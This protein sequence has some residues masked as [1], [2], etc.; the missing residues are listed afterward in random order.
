VRG[1][2]ARPG[3]TLPRATEDSCRLASS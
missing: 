2:A 3:I 1:A